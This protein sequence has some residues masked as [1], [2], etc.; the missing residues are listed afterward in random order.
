MCSFSGRAVPWHAGDPVLP[1]GGVFSVASVTLLL[2]SL[3]SAGSFSSSSS[4][5]GRSDCLALLVRG[6]L[7]L[8]VCVCGGVCFLK[9]RDL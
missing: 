7:R 4:C 2:S 8:G 6:G 9:D 1:L 5:S 3:V